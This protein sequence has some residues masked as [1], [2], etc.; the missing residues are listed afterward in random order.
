MHSPVVRAFALFAALLSGCAA[1]TS[2]RRPLGRAAAS[3]GAASREAVRTREAASRA[4]SL[5]GEAVPPLESGG[6]YWLGRRLQ[7]YPVRWGRA[8]DLAAALEPVVERLF[9][10]EARVVP[11]AA[12]N[13]IFVYIPE[14][15]ADNAPSAR[16]AT[17]GIRDG[18]R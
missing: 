13:K 5:R 17:R 4:E 15:G 1:A 6:G 9:G 7:V 14:R 16:G 8:E 18:P 2:A 10:P 11:H 12:S 3:G